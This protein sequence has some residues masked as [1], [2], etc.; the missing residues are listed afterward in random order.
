MHAIPT[1]RAY[2][3]FYPSLIVPLASVYDAS[4]ADFD[5]PDGRAKRVQKQRQDKTL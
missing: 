3:S 1:R 5:F 4:A 2:N